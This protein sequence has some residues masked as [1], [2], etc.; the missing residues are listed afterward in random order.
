MKIRNKA[1]PAVYLILYQEDGKILMGRRFNTGYMDGHY[2]VPA[3]HIEVG[4]LPKQTM[5]REAKEEIGIMLNINNLELVHISYRPKHDETDNRVD[6][7]FCA[8]EWLGEVRNLE[9]HKCDDLIWVH[10]SEL[11]EMMI[12]PHVRHALECVQNAVFFSELGVDFLKAHRVW[13]LPY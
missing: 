4:E 2:Q 11:P 10:M 13:M 7:F 6:F 12:P 3:G 1:I 5:I 9:P 8:T